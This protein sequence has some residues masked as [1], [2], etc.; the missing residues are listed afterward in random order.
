MLKADSMDLAYVI[1]VNR[2]PGLKELCQKKDTH[3]VVDK[4]KSFYPSKFNIQPTSYRLPEDIDLL[5][6]EMQ[7]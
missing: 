1:K 3:F 6:I 4:F 2:F 7:E 5:K